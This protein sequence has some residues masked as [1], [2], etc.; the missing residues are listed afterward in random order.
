MAAL[1]RLGRAGPKGLYLMPNGQN[2][3]GRSISG[4]RREEIVA[5]SHRAGVPLV[6][7]DYCADLDLDGVPN[8]PSLRALDGQVLHL[9]TFSK[10]LIPALRIGYVAFPPALRQ[11]L[12]ALKHA[13]DLGSSLLLQHALAEFLERGYLRAHLRQVLPEYRARRKALEAGLRKHMPAGVEWSRAHRGVATWLSLPATIDPEAVF[14]SALEH[15]VLVSP[16]VL[17]TVYGHERGIRL[18]FCAESPARLTLGAKRLGEALR[19]VS[20]RVTE[21]RGAA[22]SAV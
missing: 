15:G 12:A 14:T 11:H 13:M 2:P 19:E 5:W 21:N 9:G 16:D 18:T 1:E 22:L 7:D 3:T 17:F 6:E 8:P 20:A 10:R 4:K